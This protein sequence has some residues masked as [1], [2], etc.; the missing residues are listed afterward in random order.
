MAQQIA[1]RRDVDFLLHEVLRVEEMSE[2]EKFEEFNKKT[3][4]LIISE[5]RN[6]ALKEVLPTQ[7]IGDR[8]GVHFENGVVTVPEEFKKVYETY[9]EGEWVAM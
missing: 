6:L 7:V 9:R 8:Q 5:A 1:D 3:I 2:H 4:D